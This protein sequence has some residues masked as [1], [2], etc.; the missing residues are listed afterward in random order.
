MFIVRLLLMEPQCSSCIPQRSTATQRP[1]LYHN[2][3]TYAFPRS[4]F[5]HPPSSTALNAN[6]QPAVPPFADHVGEAMAD[7]A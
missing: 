1:F 3:A 5:V 4:G 2:D 6:V 7:A